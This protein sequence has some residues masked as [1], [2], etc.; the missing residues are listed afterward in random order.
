MD[1]PLRLQTIRIETRYWF[2][3]TYGNSY[4]SAQVILNDETKFCVP[5]CYGNPENAHLEII[6]VLCA[7][8]NIKNWSWSKLNELGIKIYIGSPVKVLQRVAK[9][10]GNE[11]ED[12]TLLDYWRQRNNR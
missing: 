2:D 4:Y 6:G 12:M 10:F 9:A 8:Y 5:F 11:Y 3:R 1:A 7:M